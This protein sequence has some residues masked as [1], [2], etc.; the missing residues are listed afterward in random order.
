MKLRNFFGFFFLIFSCFA[1]GI[2]ETPAVTG[3]DVDGSKVHQGNG[4]KENKK[5]DD[6][7]SDG[8]PDET[9]TVENQGT[10]SDK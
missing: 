3:G 2:V 1:L 5:S 9:E 6:N 4:N 8:N 7:D 10:V